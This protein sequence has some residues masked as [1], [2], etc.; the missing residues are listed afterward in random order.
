MPREP[1][2]ITQ[3]LNRPSATTQGADR[4]WE[5]VYPELRRRA[6]ALFRGERADHTLSA[7]AVVNE[8]FVR[9]ATQEPREWQDRSHFYAAASGIMRHVLI[10]HA[11]SRLA[12]K[13][14]GGAFRETLDEAVFPAVTNDEAGLAA[15]E[16]ALERL[17][18]THERAALV[19]AFRVFGGLSVAEVASELDV[20]P[21]TVKADWMIARLKLQELL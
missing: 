16:E 7:T 11:R 5:L 1:G 21:R 4:L 2:E 17:A 10:D 3:L 18:A 19:V 8:A 12:E 9:L 15:A 13:R 14:G 20:S 6:G